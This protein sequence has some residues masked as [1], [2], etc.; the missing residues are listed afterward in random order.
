MNIKYDME[1]TGGT[2]NKA[3]PKQNIDD[4]S[5][6]FQLFQDHNGDDDDDD[7]GDDDDGDSDDGE[8]LAFRVCG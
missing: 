4:Q 6:H 1:G 7:D 5:S 2:R 3:S 8:Q